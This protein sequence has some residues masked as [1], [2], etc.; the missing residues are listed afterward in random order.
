MTNLQLLPLSLEGAGTSEVESL[1]SYLYRLAQ[2]HGLFV[3]ELVKFIGSSIGKGPE[4]PGDV[5]LPKHPKPDELVR[6]SQSTVLL[7][8]Y[9]ENGGVQPLQESIFWLLE[10]TLCRSAGSIVK[11]FR[12][13]PEC[14]SEQQALDRPCYFKLIWHLGAVQKCPLHRTPFLSECE[15]CG[16]DQTS[17]KRAGSFDRCAQCEANLALR[18]KPLSPN[19][20]SASWQDI[21]LDVVHLLDQVADKKPSELPED[22]VRL[23]LND[24]F[25][26]YWQRREE[27]K[28]YQHLGRD[29][30]LAMMFDQTPVSLDMARRI[31]FRL[32]L[33]L[34]DLVSG[35][36]GKTTQTLIQDSLF[37]TLPDY[38]QP[39]H[40]HRH[41]HKVV[42]RRIK[43]A[44]RK[45]PEPMS[46][47]ALAGK[48][49]IS[50][51]YMDYQHPALAAEIK[52]R[53]REFQAQKQLRK[54]YQA[55]RIA[56]DFFLSEKYSEEPQSRKRAYKVLRDETGLPK[57]LL[58]KAIKTAYF[59]L[60]GS[61]DYGIGLR[62]PTTD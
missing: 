58:K 49:G 61:A 36:G 18:K 7:K 25:D 44:V 28:L 5:A 3:G 33:S 53:H 23:S 56:L 51:G 13:C 45:S 1:P 26:N 30:L 4:V 55:Q 14:F 47:K 10:H 42:L 8:T 12:W 57:H 21:G 2:L 20:I 31:A 19:V 54:T 50:V 24:I 38:L 32:G 62:L 22:G 11:G 41:N 35:N 52:L 34:F 15:H 9:L 48:V 60:N 16:C 27:E 46:L 6:P 43:A 40:R 17:Y 29:Y 37:E 39:I 59:S